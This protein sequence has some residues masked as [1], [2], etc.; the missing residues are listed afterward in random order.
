MA[1][2]CMMLSSQRLSEKLK[3][4]EEELCLNICSCL[5]LEMILY[6]KL[7]PVKKEN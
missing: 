3:K 4:G 5:K 2:G 7:S 6:L 1:L